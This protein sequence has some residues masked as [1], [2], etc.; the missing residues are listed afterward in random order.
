MAILTAALLG[1]ALV[2]CAPVVEE[3]L[4]RILK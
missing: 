1:I 4:L 2:I 3:L